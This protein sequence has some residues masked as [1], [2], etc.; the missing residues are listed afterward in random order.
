MCLVICWNVRSLTLGNVRGKGGGNKN[1]ASDWRPGINTHI[2]V[3]EP[4]KLS[5]QP[6]TVKYTWQNLAHAKKSS[7]DVTRRNYTH[8]AVSVEMKDE[9]M[10]SNSDGREGP[11]IYSVTQTYTQWRNNMLYWTIDNVLLRTPPPHTHTHR[12]RGTEMSMSH[13][14]LLI[15]AIRIY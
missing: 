6:L 8:A 12:C 11:Y 5:F 1:P 7:N 10:P 13:V 4:C 15:K 9:E 14:I 2:Y 3:S